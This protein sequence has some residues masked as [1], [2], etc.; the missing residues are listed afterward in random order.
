[1]NAATQTPAP[2]GLDLSATSPLPLV[3]LSTSLIPKSSSSAAASPALGLHFLSPWKNI[4][5]PSNGNLAATKF[6]LSLR[7]LANLPARSAL[8][9]ARWAKLIEGQVLRPV[10][11]EPI[12]PPF[13][14]EDL[15]PKIG[16]I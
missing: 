4:C 12:L 13:F 10:G 8:L 5:G 16:G 14:L 7:S 11:K 6:R 15:L 2:A 1:M 3:D 9:P